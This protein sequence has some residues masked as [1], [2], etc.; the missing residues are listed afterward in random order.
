MI[1]SMIKIICF[2]CLLESKKK[3]NITT[4]SKMLGRVSTETPLTIPTI[5]QLIFKLIRIARIIV[6]SKRRLKNISNGTAS[7]SNS[8]YRI[9]PH[10]E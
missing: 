7:N 2:Q 5:N 4:N 3:Q 6:K 10:V 9:E 8:K 1:G